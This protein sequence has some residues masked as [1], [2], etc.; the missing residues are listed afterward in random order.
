MFSKLAKED[1]ED[2]RAE[3]L[4]PSDEDVIRL[5]ALASRITDGHETTAANAPRFAVVGGIVFWEPTLA[6]LEWF[7]FARK[8]AANAGTEDLMLAFACVHA[9]EGGFLERLRDMDAVERE[10]KAFAA[11]VTATPGEVER[12]VWHVAV[13]GE[14]AQAERTTLAKELETAKTASGRERENASAAEE[15]LR[16]S[17]AATG[18]GYEELVSQTPSRLVGMIRAAHFQAGMKMSRSSARA[19]AEYLATLH[20]VAARLRAENLL[21]HGN[22]PLR[23]E[24][25]QNA[26]ADNDERKPY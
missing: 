17:A 2:L 6:A 10:M 8:S 22:V 4:A 26:N 3:G 21:P 23:V 12:A 5:H 13:D 9:R 1:L 7:D 18:L 15:I 20:A 11:S 16:A 14:S 24:P 25:T 19:H